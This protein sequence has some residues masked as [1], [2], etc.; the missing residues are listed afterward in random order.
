MRTSYTT[1]GID[2]W[3]LAV[4]MWTFFTD[5]KPFFE[6]CKANNL[7]AIASLVG[8]KKLVQTHNKYSLP[9]TT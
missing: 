6:D 2:V 3:A 7:E 4:V 9:F 8:I 5:E 1:P